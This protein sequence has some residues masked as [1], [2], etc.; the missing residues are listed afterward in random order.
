MNMNKLLPDLLPGFEKYMLEHFEDY[1]EVHTAY[2]C[3]LDVLRQ[4][5]GESEGPSVEEVK[6]AINRQTRSNL[7][8]SG[9]LGLKA[10][11]EHFRDPLAPTVLDVDFQVFLREK[12]ARILPEYQQAQA[13]L[14]RFYRLLTPLQQELYV[15]VVEYISCL[16]T[17]APKLAHFQGH[18]LGDSLLSSLVPGYKP[19][20]ELTERYRSMVN[21][22]LGTEI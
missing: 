16:E 14:S 6:E 18:L 1:Q 4:T 10:N 3:A 5:L 12:D 8:F 9:A 19:D 15:P 13:V 22:Y 17:L 7:L 20:P 11:L 21:R 2:L